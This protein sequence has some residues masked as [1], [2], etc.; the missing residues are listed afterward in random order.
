VRSS[1][2][3]SLVTACLIR[4]YKLWYKPTAKLMQKGYF[5]PTSRKQFNRFW[6]NLNFR[7]ITEDYPMQN[8]IF[9]HWRASF[10]RIPSCQSKVSSFFWFLHKHRSY[11]W[12]EFDDIYVIRR[13][14]G[15]RMC[16]LGFRWYASHLWDQI[17]KTPKRGVNRHFHWK[18]KVSNT[19]DNAGITQSQECDTRYRRMQELNSLCISK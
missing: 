14:F 17:P 19:T 4:Q 18:L 16:L 10:G 15:A 2:Y 8:L 5:D 9:I 1:L 7:T 11:Q 13:H 6:R 12:T 3:L